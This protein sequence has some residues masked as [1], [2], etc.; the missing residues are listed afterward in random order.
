MAIG[1]EYLPENKTKTALGPGWLLAAVLLF[2]SSCTYLPSGPTKSHK[3]PEGSLKLYLNFYCPADEEISCTI[4]EIQ[5]VSAD[6]KITSK[7]LDQTLKAG[8]DSRQ[9]LLE[10]S[11]PTAKY[12][13]IGFSFTEATLKRP[14]A[15]VPLEYPEGHAFVDIP[16]LITPQGTTNAYINLALS[17]KSKGG[18]SGQEFLF[19]AALSSGKKLSGL[20]SLMLYVTN[21]SDNTVTI[22]DRLTNSVVEVVQV[23][24]WPKGIVVDRAGACAYVANAGSNT[25]SMIDT[26]TNE[27]EDTI[28]LPLGI[29]PS[30]V[31]V[32]SDGKYL[33]TANTD[34]DNVSMIDTDLKRCID[35]L[36]VGHIPVD[37]RVS[38]AGQYLY[39]VNEGSND[40]YIM[41][42]ENRQLVDRVPM[43][44]EPA[45]IAVTGDNFGNDRLFVA[46]RG[47]SSILV[48]DVAGG[49]V[50][51]S[52]IL[53]GE[54]GPTKIVLDQDRDRL[55]VTNQRDNSVSSFSISIP[56]GIQNDP[57]NQGGFQENR[58]Q[59]GLSP[60]GLALDS[61]RN[62]LYVVNSGEDS[63]SIIDLRQERVV[64][65]I[66]VGKEPFGVD[67]IQK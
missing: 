54:Y 27:V 55:Y 35:T 39:V 9:I 20:K 10:T 22:L 19:A 18:E 3:I 67:L 62:F 63:L 34:S 11:L 44:S 52:S 14:G 61:A 36:R 64:E 45:G 15:T 12:Q 23:G 13:K 57:R 2:I 25:V 56:Q 66:K 24:K 58:Y 26:M 51:K 48:L 33:F 6:G 16:F 5:A 38:P 30:A 41:D 50:Q 42:I 60:I 37:L 1:P 65:S 40:L 31:A 29:S 7:P 17:S 4:Q 49:R 32:T 28:D 43:R 46:N 8:P 47:S 21:T 59:A 53:Q